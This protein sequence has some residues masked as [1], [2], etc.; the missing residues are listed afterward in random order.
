M[1]LSFLPP[2]LTHLIA[3]LSWSSV[4]REVFSTLNEILYSLYLEATGAALSQAI[5]HAEFVA[6]PTPPVHEDITRFWSEALRSHDS[7]S[8]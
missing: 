6:A 8:V 3:L 7:T 2:L 1:L 5:S 4:Q